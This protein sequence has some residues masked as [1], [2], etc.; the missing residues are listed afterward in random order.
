MTV[1]LRLDRRI[2]KNRKNKKLHTLPLSFSLMEVDATLTFE[3][4]TRD[5]HSQGVTQ[6]EYDARNAAKQS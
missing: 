5:R 6:K 4:V 2:Q 3:A 1:V